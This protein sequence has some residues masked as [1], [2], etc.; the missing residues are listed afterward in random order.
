MLPPTANV[1]QDSSTASRS[2]PSSSKGS[3]SH[4]SQSTVSEVESLKSKIQRLEEQLSKVTQGPS[5]SPRPDPR[6]SI[7]TS[8]SGIAGTFHINRESRLN[9]GQHV[10]SRNVVMHK[11][12]L[13][14]PSYWAQGASMVRIT[15]YVANVYVY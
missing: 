2:V 10:I 1:S 9:D 11:S 13:F 3:W 8:T 12:R 7:E 14:G 4:T 6:L 5:S 15:F